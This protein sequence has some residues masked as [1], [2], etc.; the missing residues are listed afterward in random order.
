MRNASLVSYA[1]AACAAATLLGGCNSNSSSV[2]APPHSGPPNVYVAD[3]GCGCVKEILAAGGYATVNK[4][5]SGFKAPSGIVLDTSGDL[6]V[7][8]NA[9]YALYEVLAIDG[10]IP[11]SPT[12]KKIASGF[13]NYPNK[14]AIDGSNNVYVTGNQRP[15]RVSGKRAGAAA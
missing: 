15:D 4:I 14:I 9:T 2:P 3:I 7:V 1:V 8:D 10:S 6:F 13:T 12:V 11:R 5:V